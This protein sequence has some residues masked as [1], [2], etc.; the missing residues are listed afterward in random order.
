[1]ASWEGNKWG[2]RG[3]GRRRGV[4][5]D[6][7]G[8]LG[9]QGNAEKGLVGIKGELEGKLGGLVSLYGQRRDKFA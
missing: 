7:K 8:Y 3:K 9:G 6:W 2:I 4:I 5:T 1:M